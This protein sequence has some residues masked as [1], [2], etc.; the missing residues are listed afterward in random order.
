MYRACVEYEVPSLITVYCM[1]FFFMSQVFLFSFLY[2]MLIKL[3]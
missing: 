3:G 1:Q 2:V